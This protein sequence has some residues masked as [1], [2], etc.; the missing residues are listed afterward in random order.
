[1]PKTCNYLITQNELVA[2]KTNCMKENRYTRISGSIRIFHDRIALDG[3]DGNSDHFLPD[4]A[5]PLKPELIP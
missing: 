5:D 4:T 2:K 3:K 1:M